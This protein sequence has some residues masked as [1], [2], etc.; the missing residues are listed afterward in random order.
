MDR[1]LLAKHSEGLIGING[2]LGSEIG[3]HLLAFE[4]TGEAKWWEKAVESAKW[5][6]ATFGE[7]NFFVELQHHVAEQN[8]INKHLIRLAQELGLP[9]VCDND[10]HFLRAEDHDAHDTLICISM[11]K[12]KRDPDRLHYPAELYV[13]SP[14][15][16]RGL[17]E[18]EYGEVGREACDNTLR[19]AE[20]CAG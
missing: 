16:M 6:A 11:G 19:I 12:V 13:K 20:R 15:E 7:G 8:S 9:L 1:E 5:H 18:R 3:E 17:F 2:H 10:S 14:E 4:R